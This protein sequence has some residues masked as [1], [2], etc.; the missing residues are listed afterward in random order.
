MFCQRTKIF[1]ISLHW[2][3]YLGGYF[4]SNV[5]ECE[6]SVCLTPSFFFYLILYCFFLALL[7]SSVC[8]SD[9]LLSYLTVEETLTYTAQLALRKHSAQA[10]KK[11]VT[12]ESS[13]AC[14][15]D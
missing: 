4:K 9:N 6:G 11:K 12:F 1:L 7:I 2:A 13:L 5:N 3:W 10:I 8:Q 15:L 14:P